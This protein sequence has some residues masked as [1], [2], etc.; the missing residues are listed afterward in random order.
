MPDRFID[1]SMLVRYFTDD[2]PEQAAIAEAIVET[3]SLL[4]NSV[5]LMECGYVLTRLYHYPRA[6]VIDVLV[7]FLRRSNVQMIDLP[8][9]RAMAALAR[10][11]ESGRI[12]I[13]DAL[14]IAAMQAR[15]VGEIYAFDQRLEAEGIRV[16]MRA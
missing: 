15:G 5:I 6:D 4:V 14:I 7:K 3:Q 13:G 10:C 8:K 11:R 16:L 9:E 2:I 1:T 12:S